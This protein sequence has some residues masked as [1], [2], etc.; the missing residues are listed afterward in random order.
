VSA[1]LSRSGWSVLLPALVASAIVLVPGRAEPAAFALFEEGARGMGFA[2]AFT[3]Q[4]SDPS[5]IFHNAAGIAFLKGNHLSLGGTLITPSTDFVGDS[6]YPGAGQL[7]TM[8]VGPTPIPAIYFTHQFTSRFV[9]GVGLNTPFGL[10]TSWDSPDTFTGRFLSQKA[11]LKGFSLN[12]T[13]AYKL[14]DRLSA[15]F[16]VDVRLT[17]VSLEQA[18][19]AVNPFTGLVVDASQVTLNSDTATDFGWNMGVYGKPTENLSFGVSY[20]SKVKQDFSGIAT[21]TSQ[22]TGNAEL[23]AL[24]ALNLPS[25]ALPATTSIEFPSIIAVGVA[26]S[27]QDWTVEGD[28]DFYE[29]ST[30]D[31]LPVNIDGPGL[32]SVVQEDYSNTRQYRIGLERRIQELWAV[33]GGYYYDESPAPVES[34]SPLLPDSARQGFCL[35]GSWSQG[36]FRLDAA[37]W[38]VKFKERS[39]DGQ[40]RDGYN[41]TYKGKAITFGLSFG[42]SF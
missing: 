5:A 3:A 35:G 23:N 15:G 37:A 11:E 40:Q 2:G 8:N 42:Y 9:A 21:F 32:S 14:A 4:A 18:V 19:P 34:V 39:T 31:A 7:E 29:W 41:G 17:S 20:R 16:G 27:W 22:D 10:K 25:G 1:M 6:P 36:Q 33:R 30:F 26:Y 24:I 28:I 38:Y 13:I 12:P